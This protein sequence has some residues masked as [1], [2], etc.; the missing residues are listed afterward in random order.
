M[1]VDPRVQ[2]L[3][4][5]ILE[6]ERTPEEVCRDCPE[7]LS[8]VRALLER[9]RAVEKQLGR[10]FPKAESDEWHTLWKH[11]DALLQRDRDQS[12]GESS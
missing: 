6:S 10:L 5:K 7:L 2:Q 3:L 1:T 8:E 4:E 11:I 9:I 12:E